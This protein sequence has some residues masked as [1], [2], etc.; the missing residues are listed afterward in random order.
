VTDANGLSA[1]G[2]VPV[3]VN[4][5]FTSIGVSPG[6]ATV[7]PGLS[8]QFTATAKDQFGNAISSQPLIT[9]SVNGGGAISNTGLFTA[10]STSGGPFTVTAA[11]GGKSG[12][13]KVTVGTTTSGAFVWTGKG[14]TSNWSEA[15]NWST[16][17]VPG[18]SATVVFNGTSA[19]NATVDST[20]AGS[21]A[22]VEIVSGYT[23]TV[24]LSRSLTIG[25]SL[26]E[27]GGTFSAGTSTLYIA[28]DLTKTGGTF[29]AGTG[30]V[31]MT[32]TAANQNISAAGVAFYNFVLAN[33]AHSLN[34]TGTLT[35][36][37][38]FT[39]LRTA[40]W[41]LGPNASGNAAIECRG[42]IDDQNHGNTGTPYFTLDGTGNQTIKD[43][44][45]VLNYNGF[46]G[47]DYRGLT[48]N[49][50]SG[51]VILACDPLVYNGLSLQK[52]TVTSGSNFWLVGNETVS[53][54]SGLNLG[55][56]T[57]ST[58]VAAGSWASGLQVANLNLNGH[59]LVAPASLYV[60]GNFNASG[61]GSSFTANGGTIIFDGVS[62][63]P[64]QLT[65]GGYALNNLTIN[66]GATVQL[67]DDLKVLGTLTIN[68]V[69][70][71]NGHKLNGV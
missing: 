46:S 50:T 36:N 65:S 60:S 22:A 20:F 5:T 27:S 32:G 59:S 13:A 37:G 52:G 9:W 10:G 41:I 25:G 48:I 29:N 11:G 31:A 1:I 8:Q 15:A 66:S 68:G 6:T 61:S 42:D 28:G 7:G 58:N 19:K 63:S 23:G 54:A 51:S 45:G 56:V 49:K 2:T 57:V 69:L 12:T 34:V 43:T 33:S 26:S 16:N 24:S 71:K 70:N 17:V 64:Q 4:T 14:S 67:Q 47:G 40:G 44:S 55:N 21:V 35:V 3:T 39:W 38:T 18:S 30:S 53:T 62:S